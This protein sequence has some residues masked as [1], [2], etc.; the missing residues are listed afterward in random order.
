MNLIRIFPEGIP[1]DS[2]LACFI[3]SKVY[4]RVNSSD[5]F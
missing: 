3:L 5:T 2:E 4:L 1:T